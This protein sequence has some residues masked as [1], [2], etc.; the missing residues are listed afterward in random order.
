MCQKKCLH[1][2]KHCTEGIDAVII[3][4]PSLWFLNNINGKLAEI[5]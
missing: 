5:G 4:E 1:W 3:K 2:K